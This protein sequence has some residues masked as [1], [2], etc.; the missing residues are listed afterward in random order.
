M[1][2]FLLLM[3]SKHAHSCV[4]PSNVIS[5]NM[6]ILSNKYTTKY[7]VVTLQTNCAQL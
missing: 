5:L 1:E 3:L 6:L 4:A 7:N 2:A